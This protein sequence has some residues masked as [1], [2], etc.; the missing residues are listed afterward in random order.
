MV[1]RSKKQALESRTFLNGA[2]YLYK[3]KDSRQ[4]CWDV[5]LKIYGHKGYIHRTSGTPD[6]HEAYS[7]AYAAYLDLVAMQ[8]AGRGLDTK[9]I[10]T[11]LD[12]FIQ[13]HEQKGIARNFRFTVSM[14]RQMRVFAQKRSFSEI[15]TAF[16]R[17]TLEYL[18]GR[19]TRGELSANTH[20]RNLSRLKTILKWWCEEG[21]LTKLP[22]FPSL[23]GEIRRRPDFS[24]EDWIKLTAAMPAFLEIDHGPTRR[25]RI[26]L[27]NWVMILC[28]TGL[29]T[30]E[31]RQLRW[32]DIRPIVS[33][34][35]PSIVNVALNVTGKTGR[36]TAVASSGEVKRYFG[37]IL[38]L[39]K[40]DLENPASDIY[41]KDRVPTDSLVFCHPNGKPIRSFRKS[42]AS[43]LTAAGV[44][45]NS[46]GERRSPYSLR[47]TYA[48]FRLNNG[49]QEYHL[50]RNM[51]TSVAMLEQH[52]GHTS[53]T[54]NVDELTK[55]RSTKARSKASTPG[56]VKTNEALIWLDGLGPQPVTLPG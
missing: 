54:A 43:L 23:P 28:N 24:Q 16:V 56:G 27:V 47:H 51:G 21:Y 33:A 8:R 4:G 7:R 39:R 12:A 10:T 34:A 42:F 40:K 19:S 2:I 44:V 6:E 45:S 36:R 26:M 53:N 5:R 20:R 22:T 38:E 50:A 17:Q 1:A 30:G 25:D 52:Y 14:A 41:G 48:T 46:E 35:D 18:A 11:G 49:V 13:H 15:D 32:H 31:A 37:Q 3:R 55:Q 9:R 29:R